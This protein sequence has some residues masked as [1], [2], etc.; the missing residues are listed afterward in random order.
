[1]D[2]TGSTK[3]P[4]ATAH[5]LQNEG[6]LTA[7]R[8]Q[9]RRPEVAWRDFILRDA[10]TALLTGALISV[11][12]YVAE[13]R[14]EERLLETSERLENV[15]FIRQL[16]ISSPTGP[17]PFRGVDLHNSQLTNVN[18]TFADLRD[19]DLSGADL[20][21]GD[22]S[23]AD[24]VLVDFSG[25]NL[26]GA[27][28]TEANLGGAKLAKA[29]LSEADLGDANL[30][31]ADLA[32]ADLT[33][34]NL[35]GADL[36]AADLTGADLTGADFTGADLTSTN[37]TGV[38]LADG[39]VRAASPTSPSRTVFGADFTGVWWCPGEPPPIWP[40][41]FSP[42]QSAVPPPERCGS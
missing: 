38:N 2:S 33:G 35:G 26:S 13:S 39:Y 5:N 41:G 12:L 30:Q 40:V 37:L 22:L 15:R 32:D 36:W 7:G 4:G 34:A 21:Y 16:S 23:G 31:F 8:R 1:M 18:L 28:L 10:L 25:A 14:R 9:G 3:A 42:P 27:K 29:H 20:R 17:K 11:A 19:A 6:E 24:L